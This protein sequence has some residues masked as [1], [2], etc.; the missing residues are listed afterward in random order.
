MGIRCV[1]QYAIV[2]LLQFAGELAQFVENLNLSGLRV[3][4]SLM[5]STIQTSAGINCPKE[6]WKALNE[7]DA[8]SSCRLPG[9]SCF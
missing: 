3:W 2:V 9:L 4:T 1:L 7:I 6:H 5:K 8:V